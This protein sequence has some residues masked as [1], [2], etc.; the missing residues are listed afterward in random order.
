M[1]YVIGG[2]GKHENRLFC[3]ARVKWAKPFIIQLR[4]SF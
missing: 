2:G 1:N 4:R 3:V